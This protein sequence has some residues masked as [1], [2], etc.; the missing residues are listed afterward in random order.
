MS[1]GRTPPPDPV[2]APP[3]P[4]PVPAPEQAPPA[5][6][7]DV[8]IPARNPSALTGYY[9]G[10]FSMIPGL[11]LVLGPLAIV[12]GRRARAALAQKPSIGGGGHATAA[13]V[14]GW[15]GIVVSVASC[16]VLVVVVRRT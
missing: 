6:A 10:V 14:L 9:L 4:P 1:D 15:L 3:P 5:S 2:P 8:F 12:A 16:F 7:V 13:I 11:G